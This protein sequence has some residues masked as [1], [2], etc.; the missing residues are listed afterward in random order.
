MQNENHHYRKY[1]NHQRRVIR[2]ELWTYSSCLMIFSDILYF[3]MGFLSSALMKLLMWCWNSSPS[4]NSSS[5]SISEYA[6]NI[7]VLEIYCHCEIFFIQWTF[8]FVFLCAKDIQ[9]I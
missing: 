8:N 6:E 3:S 1:E 7:N 5:P 9:Q 4:G 2:T